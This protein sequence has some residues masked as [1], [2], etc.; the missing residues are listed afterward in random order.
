[1][2]SLRQDEL[3]GPMQGLYEAKAALSAAIDVLALCAQA[4]A[5]RVPAHVWGQRVQRRLEKLSL[6]R[7]KATVPEQ[8][9]PRFAALAVQAASRW[10]RYAAEENQRAIGEALAQARHDT[11]RA[12]AIVADAA[13][14]L[15]RR[16]S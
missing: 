9:L 5:E 3:R 14:S 16:R 7:G 15:A 2:H 4:R 1:M 6:P 12:L 8:D 10:L 11:Y 13:R